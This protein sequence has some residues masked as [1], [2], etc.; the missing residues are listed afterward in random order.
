M[1]TQTLERSVADARSEARFASLLELYR[2]PIARLAAAYE[3]HRADQ[4]DL[5]QEIWFAVWRDLPTFRGDCSERTFGSAT[6]AMVPAIR[7][8][9]AGARSRRAVDSRSRPS[10]STR[11]Q[12]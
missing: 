12:L 11:S 9:C 10:G 3:R 4:E 6:K 5:V 1:N 7:T 2:A 8:A